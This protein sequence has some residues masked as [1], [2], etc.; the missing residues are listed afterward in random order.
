MEKYVE[1]KLWRVLENVNNWLGYAERKNVLILTFIGIQLTLCKLF[2]E[3]VDVWL[4]ACSIF[5]GLCFLLTLISF[6]PQT[7]I[8]WWLYFWARSSDK[9]NENDNLLFYG[10]ITKYSQ[11]EYI[12]KME[13]YFGEDIHGHK[14]LEDLCG[15]IVVNSQIASKK[16]N[17]FKA[18]TWFMITG[19]M[20]LLISFWR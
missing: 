8:P 13:K 1:D 20:L 11:K 4:I 3:D 2:V 15:Q 16:F 12:E 5:L 10:D 19:Q 7:V 17:I 9:P 6:F 14:N 18:T